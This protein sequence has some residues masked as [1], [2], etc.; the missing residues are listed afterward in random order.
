[1]NDPQQ[2]SIDPTEK[3]LYTEPNSDHWGTWRDRLFQTGSGTRK[4]IG[5]DIAGKVYVLSL[6]KWHELAL[7]GDS[8]S[9]E[10]K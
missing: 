5:I 7:Q 3:T 9:G 8:V 4:G 6:K 2:T 1:M 10:K